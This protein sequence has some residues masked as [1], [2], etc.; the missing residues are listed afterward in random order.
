MGRYT[1]IQAFADNNP[2]M[3]KLPYDEAAL[4]SSKTTDEKTGNF[5][6]GVTVEKVN[7]VM[8]STAGAGSGEYHMYRHGRRRERERIAAME[9][10]AEELQKHEEFES[11]VDAKRKECEDRTRKNA[12]V[13]YLFTC[14]RNR[15][16]D[17]LPTSLTVVCSTVLYLKQHSH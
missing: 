9:R 2:G 12:Q 16:G 15:K 5:G 1:T 10:G 13:N 11:R 6:T 3:A 8:G 4:A 14:L 7:N 17:S